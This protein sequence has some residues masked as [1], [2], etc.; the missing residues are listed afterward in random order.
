MI[1]LSTE[2]LCWIKGAADDQQDQ[3]AHGRV[4]FRVNDTVFVKPGDGEWAVSGAGLFL[5]RTL[6]HDHNTGK[7][8]AESNRLFPCCAFNV[9]PSDGR[10]KVLCM[11]CDHGIDVQITHGDGGVVLESARGKE[12]VPEKEWRQAVLNFVSEVRAFYDRCTPKAKINDE[13]DC[14]GWAAFWREWDERAHA[15]EA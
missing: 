11:G 12:I 3:C 15:I 7:P 8:V 14:R 5:L 1:T 9:W 10:F 13:L 4:N 6:R 2:N